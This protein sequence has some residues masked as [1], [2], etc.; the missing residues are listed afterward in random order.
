MDFPIKSNN[1]S[2]KNCCIALLFLALLTEFFTLKSPIS[3]GLSLPGPSRWAGPD[4]VHHDLSYMTNVINEPLPLLILWHFT[5]IEH[6][7]ILLLT[8]SNEMKISSIRN[9]LVLFSSRFPSG[10]ID[11]PSSWTRSRHHLL[12]RDLCHDRCHLGYIDDSH[13]TTRLRGKLGHII[14]VFDLGWKIDDHDDKR[15]R[16]Q[17]ILRNKIK[18]WATIHLQ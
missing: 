10:S 11:V 6:C 18:K 16:H 7:W 3:G 17:P 2:L 15:E 5:S 8:K 13:H 12:G 9:L 4:C 14:C 1:T